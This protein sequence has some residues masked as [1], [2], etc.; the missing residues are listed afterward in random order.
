M[1]FWVCSIIDCPPP[2]SLASILWV[3][4]HLWFIIFLPPGEEDYQTKWKCC[5]AACVLTKRAW[6]GVRYQNKCKSR[7][8][9]FLDLNNGGIISPVRYSR[10]ETEVEGEMRVVRHLSGE[11]ICVKDKQECHKSYWHVVPRPI[12]KEGSKCHGSI[13]RF[14]AFIID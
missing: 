8:D 12:G 14:E 6:A 7:H 9:T 10:Y 4:W 11:T 3:F 2:P 13:D 5:W 1:T